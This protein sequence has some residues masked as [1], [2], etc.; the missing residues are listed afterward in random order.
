MEPK[1]YLSKEIALVAFIAVAVTIFL[2]VKISHFSSEIEV[3]HAA[4]LTYYVATSG[5][6]SNAGTLSAPFR[7][8]QKA[9]NTAG[10]GDTVIVRGGTYTPIK[11]G[12]SATQSQPFV[13]RAYPNERPIIDASSGGDRGIEI[14]SGSSWI[15]IEGFEIKNASQEGIKYYDTNNVTIR[16]NIIHHNANH[17]IL[18]SGGSNPTL[19]GN[20]IH[21]NGLFCQRCI[22][23]DSDI[24]WWHHGAYMDGTNG[25]ANNNIFYE[26]AAFGLQLSGSNTTNWII[27]NNTF[28]NQKDNSG[29]I[30]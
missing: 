14:S 8:I 13:I 7:T 3:A 16:K 26:N 20:I 29:L 17:G 24:N 22:D 12:K 15:V 6:D 27:A 5:S 1:N 28:A 10:V 21:N 9:V 30:F 19:E 25:R 2:L 11:F 4:G 18:G 23:R